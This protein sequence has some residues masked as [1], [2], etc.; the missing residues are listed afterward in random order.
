MERI[1]EKKLKNIVIIGGSHSGFSAAWMIL[2]GPATYNR[3]NIYNKK[4]SNSFPDA[5]IKSNPHCIECC[6]CSDAK[7][8]K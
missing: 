8:K 1:N 7:K 3:N 5:V 4:Q 2:N 6:T